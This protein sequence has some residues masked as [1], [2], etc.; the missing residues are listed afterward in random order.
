VVDVPVDNVIVHV[1]FAG[2]FYQKRRE[3]YLVK[4]TGNVSQENWVIVGLKELGFS[5]EPGMHGMPRL[6]GQGVNIRKHIL[7][8]VHQDVRGSLVAAGGKCATAFSLR[9]VAIAPAT[10]Q[11]I[12]ERA[13][14]FL[15]ERSQGSYDFIDRIIE[16]DMCFNFGN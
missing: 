15:A 9:F 5:G 10:A 7:L 4:G 2:L 13:R 11:T 12:G 1:L 6:V 16:T 8:V 14:V 3:Q